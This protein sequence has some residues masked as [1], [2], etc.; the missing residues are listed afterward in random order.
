MGEY[1]KERASFIIV[2]VVIIGGF[3]FL[4]GHNKGTATS[5]VTH[6]A[7]VPSPTAAMTSPM[8]RGSKDAKV[9]LIQYSDFLCPSCSYFTTQVMPTIQQKYIDT[10]KVKFEFRPI[11]FIAEGS[12]L[13][14]EGAYCAIDQGKFWSYHDAVYAYV[15][16]TAFSK[17]VDPKTT[18]ILTSPILD[19]L[20]STIGL[21]SNLFSDCLS[22]GK[23]A[24]HVSDA[25]NTANTQGVTS[26]PY[27]LV[28]GKQL[29]GNP[30]IQ[31]VEALI[32]SQL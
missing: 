9:S 11:A 7:N 22:S 5:A 6:P 27:I 31:T 1:L 23:Y 16:N 4:M 3:V 15:W 19:T 30:S 18:T 8:S 24:T 2:V 21:D 26:T 32:E 25:T 10:G 13:A 29:T 28:N 17:G 20:A 12:T 14:D